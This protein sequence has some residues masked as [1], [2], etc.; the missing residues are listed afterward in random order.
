MSEVIEHDAFLMLDRRV[1]KL[2]I[3][4]TRPNLGRFLSTAVRR[5]GFSGGIPGR[6]K[7]ALL[8]R[9]SV[10]RG[11]ARHISIDAEVRAMARTIPAALKA[12]PLN[13][14]AHVGAGGRADMKLAGFIAIDS[15]LFQARSN[16]CA[17]IFWNIIE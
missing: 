8:R 17:G 16:N 7:A 9:E 11:A 10:Y 5:G 14:A 2:P 15:K 6:L 4:A 1:R 3:R 13:N 12:I